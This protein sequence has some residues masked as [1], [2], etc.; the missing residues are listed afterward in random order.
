M[1]VASVAVAALTYRVASQLLRHRAKQSQ[2]PADRAWD[3]LYDEWVELGT[4]FMTWW[5]AQG[6][7]VRMTV[8]RTAR[9]AV[10]AE[11]GKSA[12]AIDTLCP[13]LRWGAQHATATEA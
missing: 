7:D 5:Q 10:R 3:R 9:D 11:L 1:A 12:A 6:M 13:E 2:S 8:L 4:A